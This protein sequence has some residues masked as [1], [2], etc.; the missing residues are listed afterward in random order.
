MLSV[1]WGS[2]IRARSE[3]SMSR[4]EYK[5]T[6]QHFTPYQQCWLHIAVQQHMSSYRGGSHDFKPLEFNNIQEPIAT[7]ARLFAC[8]LLSRR[9]VGH[10]WYADKT[11]GTVSYEYVYN[12]M[13]NIAGPTR[14]TRMLTCPLPYPCHHSCLLWPGNDHAVLVLRGAS[15]HCVH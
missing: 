8:V 5:G 11:G 7:L 10:M 15:V 14:F 3:F 2:A 6:V 9:A 12:R 13:D 1:N 4:R